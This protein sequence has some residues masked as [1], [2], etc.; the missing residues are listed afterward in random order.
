MAV[1]PGPIRKPLDA[2]FQLVGYLN[3]N[4]GLVMSM[5]IAY[6]VF[7]P[8][9]AM[10]LHFSSEFFLPTAHAA[11]PA[12]TVALGGGL[13]GILAALCG[14]VISVIWLISHTLN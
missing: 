14:A 2:A 5:G 6:E 10:A 3:A 1:F 12:T 7:Q 9:V 4:L 13:V 11:D 8:Q